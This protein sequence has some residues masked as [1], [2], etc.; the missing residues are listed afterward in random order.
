MSTDNCHFPVFNQRLCWV[1][2]IQLALNRDTTSIP[3]NKTCDDEGSF[4][5]KSRPRTAAPLL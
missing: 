5:G 3:K 1:F 4:L 2:F